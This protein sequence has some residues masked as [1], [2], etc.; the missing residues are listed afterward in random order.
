MF[1][2]KFFL[3]NYSRPYPLKVAVCAK[4]Y[5]QTPLAH[6]FRSLCGFYYILRFFKI[7]D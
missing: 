5:Y 1:K 6:T 2:R 7:L 4:E 3:A